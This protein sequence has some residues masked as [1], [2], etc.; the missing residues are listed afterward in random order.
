ME[1]QSY[2]FDVK[3]HVLGP[4]RVV[5]EGQDLRLGGPKQRLTLA[6]LIAADG[7][8]MSTSQ[9]ID[10]VWGE[11]PPA[12]A[13]K[14]LQGHV[15]HLRAAVGERLE[16]MGSGY[17]LRLSDELDASRFAQL[18]AEA[19]ALVDVDAS[20]ASDLLGEALALWGGAAYSDLLDQDAIGPAATRLEDAR[21]TALGDRLDA[22][23]KLGRHNDLI[24]EIDALTHEYPLHERFR[25]QHML[26]LYRAG[27]QVEALRSF[28]RFRKAM[29][30]E[31]GVAPS[32]ALQELEHQ[33]LSGSP[34][35]DVAG[36]DA[37]GVVP[38]VRGYELRE[39]LAA[40]HESETYRG[41]QRSVGREVHINV[42]SSSVADDPTFI[43][44]H[45]TDARR[46]AELEHPNISVVLDVWREPGR[47][48]QVSRWFDGG[49][50][51][52]RLDD[53]AM[54]M[55]TGLRYIDE[56]GD[57]LS[58][59]HRAGL[60]HGS[61][62]ADSIVL[63]SSGHSYLTGFPIGRAEAANE[64]TDFDAFVS[65]AHL[66]VGG[67]APRASGGELMPDLEGDP[68]VTAMVPVFENAFSG[69]STRVKDFVRALRRAAGVD[70]VAPGGQPRLSVTRN[71]Y[72]GLQAFQDSDERDF[73]GRDA[74]IARLLDKVGKEH[75]VAVVGPSGSGKS[76][77][78]KAGLAAQLRTDP[79]R[80]LVTEMYPGAYPFEELESALLRVGVNRD[81]VIA[82]LVSDDRGL[83]RVV[84]QIVPAEDVELILVIDQFEELFSMGGDEEQRQLFLDSLLV[85][86]EDPRSQLRVVLTMRADYYDRPLGYPAFGERFERGLIS[87]TA[88]AD[89]E[90]A[91]AIAQPA[92]SVE[93]TF[94]QGLVPHIV[95]DVS[96]QAGALPLLQFAMTTLFEGRTSDVLSFAEY[97]DGGGI[98]GSIGRR[99]EELWA[100][101]TD[102]QRH[103]VRQ[104]LLRMVAI[105]E[106]SADLR[107][108][109]R[110]ADLRAPDI[111]DAA[112]THVLQLFGAHRLVTFD[113]DPVTRGATV[114]VAHEALLR[115]WPRL[116][117]WLEG[118][119]DE[120]ATRRQLAVAIAEW[121][122]A[123]RDV[124]YLPTG[125]R[126]ARYSE[127]A[128]STELS[129]S[130]IERKYLD[131]GD[132]RERRAEDQARLR[133]RRAGAAL[134]AVASVLAV[135]AGFAL[136][137]RRDANHSA[138]LA[139]ESAQIAARQ[140]QI[141]ATRAEE[142]VAA[143]DLADAIAFNAVTVS[144]VHS[145]EALS[146]ENRQLAMLLAVE[147]FSRDASATTRGAL[148]RV[149]LANSG[150]L[151][152]LALGEDVLDVRWWGDDRIVALTDSRLEVLVYPSGE[153]I[154]SV[155][156]SIGSYR[157]LGGQP[158]FAFAPEAGLVA[159]ESA[160]LD[161]GD[162]QLVDLRTG[163]VEIIGHDHPITALALSPDG[164]MLAIGDVTR[165]I[166]I[167]GLEETVADRRWH[168]HPEAS[169]DEVVE[170]GA[171]SISRQ[172]V[173]DI[174][175]ADEES[176]AFESISAL[177]FNEDGTV[178]A[179][180]SGAVVRRWR[181]LTG[182]QLG[183]DHLL[184]PEDPEIE[185]VWS[186]SADSMPYMVPARIQFVGDRLIASE[187]DLSVSF[188]DASDR[189][190]LIVVSPERGAVFSADFAAETDR[191]MVHAM[192]NGE[193][194]RVDLLTG[195]RLSSVS[196]QLGSSRA[197]ALNS[198]RDVA[199][200]ATENGVVVM[201]MLGGSY[202]GDALTAH[203]QE[204]VAINND[205]SLVSVTG[206]VGESDTP[207]DPEIWDT[208]TRRK[209]AKEVAA[210]S[211]LLFVTDSPE[212]DQLLEWAEVGG[213][214]TLV[215]R[216]GTLG[217]VAYRE[218]GAQPRF[219]P[220][221]SLMVVTSTS[222]NILNPRAARVYSLQTGAL[223]VTIGGD[224]S[225][226][227]RDFALFSPDS[228]RLFVRFESGVRVYDT[229][230]L[231]RAPV[232]LGNAEAMTFSRDGSV[233]A[234]ATPDNRLVMLDGETYAE[235][236]SFEMDH[237]AHD[238]RFDDDGRHLLVGPDWVVYDIQTGE[239]VGDPF[240]TDPRVTAVPSGSAALQ[241]A[242]S[243]DNVVIV[244]NLDLTSWAADTCAAV[245]RNLSRAEWDRFGP[246]DDEYRATCPQFP[247]ED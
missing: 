160:G 244:W 231:E 105:D 35:L 113:R 189:W 70:A 32:L 25:A 224:I 49:M 78:V 206:S 52:A 218:G 212:A 180:A 207:P 31:L 40:D 61:V 53:S 216:D 112:M 97:L 228:S 197:L 103:A 16:T 232:K 123:D 198:G 56:I 202:L 26:A 188:N 174:T 164:A 8:A 115:E 222:G 245:G 127:W 149:A 33:I 242:T 106:G 220:D 195:E 194:R 23:L 213:R 13:R 176:Q 109:V 134:V 137:A 151:A 43:D 98:F 59:V 64:K 167:R 240:P 71:P 159:L 60:A 200:L 19:T 227:G 215:S 41:Y 163:T 27:R 229:A 135:I 82:D 37:E 190:P 124:S 191:V 58:H 235:I 230:S 225:D 15:H 181:M 87:L 80:R 246:A 4:V 130:E 62:S 65:L 5:S 3:F 208:S 7:K 108:R 129:L 116:G 21:V 154:V 77:V 20:R 6:L 173:L 182:E 18:H 92:A 146:G 226:R 144:L 17:L 162:V 234:F 101:L 136:L 50:L 88:L 158:Q 155:A 12:T 187:R 219:S 111:D 243:V 132:D 94:E 2:D 237:E 118:Q 223:L 192:S 74:L 139:A 122:S 184:F 9:L 172:L 55:T 10:G 210:A 99:A 147:A 102:P 30:E 104:A 217:A 1:R 125:G 48:Y 168:G 57:A 29:V 42:L 138:D 238:L 170:L 79:G 45:L 143:A 153:A 107:R 178:L 11:A 66:L 84:K 201:S 68:A 157:R 179:S 51:S 199:A 204:R 140:E 142:A 214:G 193:L 14:T 171:T 233:L 150:F 209:V 69:G 131:D 175:I 211:W 47:A 39:L 93:V 83:M 34:D 76:S 119:R 38:A 110:R 186:G 117:T 196:A 169:Y 145:A 46:I 183:V 133:R 236:T 75:L 152:Y 90:L 63:S 95:A 44:T 36:G 81:S 54:T 67:R 239:H 121:E 166:Q 73:Y 177:T 148:Q 28:E 120:L 247:I 185:H 156:V 241:L 100:D 22:N 96:G 203:S 72:K 114:E 165:S 126:L 91:A 128:E 205:G 89:D 221:G 161:G 24:G 141:A 85:A 86:T